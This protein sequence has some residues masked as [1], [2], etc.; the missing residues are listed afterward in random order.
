VNRGFA[1]TD[2]RNREATAERS[3]DTGAEYPVRK[4]G[5]MRYDTVVL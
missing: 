5:W 1:L 3:T 4:F 2:V